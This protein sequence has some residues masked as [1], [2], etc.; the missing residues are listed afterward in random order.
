MARAREYRASLVVDAAIT[1]VLL[2]QLRKLRPI[3]WWSVK[4]WRI[5]AHAP[6]SHRVV[7]LSHSH[8]QPSNLTFSDRTAGRCGRRGNYFLHHNFS[9]SLS[10]SLVAQARRPR[11]QPTRAEHARVGTRGTGRW[12]GEHSSMVASQSEWKGKARNCCAEKQALG[13]RSSPRSLCLS[14]L[15]TLP[16]SLFTLSLSRRPQTWTPCASRPSSSRAAL[17]LE[18]TTDSGASCCSALRR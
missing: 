7:T 12:A 18:L 5:H 15:F 17:P 3:K 10:R 1:A 8:T 6:G 16:L 2:V 4:L 13:V 14:V 11:T 9:L